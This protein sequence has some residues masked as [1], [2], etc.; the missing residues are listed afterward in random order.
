M[1]G[2]VDG[3]SAPSHVCGWVRDRNDPQAEIEVDVHKDGALIGSGW[4]IQPRTDLGGACGFRVDCGSDIELADLL[5]DR[6][7]VVARQGTIS[8]ELA[9]V[10]AAKRRFAR[11]MLADT[12]AAMADDELI[13]L[14]REIAASQSP[15]RRNL[16]AALVF[17]AGEGEASPKEVSSLS[18]VYFP[19]GK[20]SVDGTARLEADGFICLNETQATQGEDPL[21][22][23]QA[24]EALV[25]Q[26]HATLAEQGRRFLQ[27]VIPE[28]ATLLGCGRPSEANAIFS[29]VEARL[30]PHV[31]Y[32]SAMN[33][34]SVHPT[35]YLRKVDSHLLPTGCYQL[36]K[37]IC[38]AA[39]FEIPPVAIETPRIQDGDLAARLVGSPVFEPV[40]HPSPAYAASA[41]RDLEVIDF[42]DSTSAKHIGSRA[43][44]R[45]PGAPCRSKVAVFGNSF[46]SLG[47][48]ATQLSWWMMRLFSEYH[49]L[50]SPEVS[51]E[52]AAKHGIE[53]VIAQTIERYLPRLPAR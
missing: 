10:P 52:Y 29:H 15:V 9:V 13:A 28:K 43:V 19:L 44:W 48:D 45:N 37:A 34:L 41:V 50:W 31:H 26:R 6:V 49:F 1:D 3:F 16:A 25:S 11:R 23:A 38:R 47:E 18:P 30:A 17:V 8:M 27:I 14:L 12:I 20:R 24:W 39:G 40:A 35:A 51:E 7:K 2:V 53:I 22:R 33:I 46:F 4:A 32:V 36:V 21:A 42:F 5:S